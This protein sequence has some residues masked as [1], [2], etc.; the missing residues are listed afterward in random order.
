[1]VTNEEEDPG[2]PELLFN[3]DGDHGSSTLPIFSAVSVTAYMLL[4][5]A[6]ITSAQ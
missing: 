3:I 6:V 4:I 1:M 5:D 2:K